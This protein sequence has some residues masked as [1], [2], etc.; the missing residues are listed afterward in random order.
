M[1]AFFSTLGDI[2]CS[3]LSRE[4]LVLE[5]SLHIFFIFYILFFFFLFSIF[6][7]GLVWCSISGVN[8]SEGGSRRVTTKSSNFVVCLVSATLL[9]AG[10]FYAY[11][12]R[13]QKS[14]D[15]CGTQLLFIFCTIETSDGRGAPSDFRI[16]KYIL[17]RPS[18]AAVTDS[19][20]CLATYSYP[21]LEHP[22]LR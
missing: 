12:S 8:L 1:T 11:V 5:C 16:R 15:V 21:T 18:H 3:L 6:T 7:F 2:K 9:T 20:W 10:L 19:D 4:E 22:D 13:N 17:V 14:K